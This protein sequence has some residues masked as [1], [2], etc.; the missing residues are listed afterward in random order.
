MPLRP[1]V[2]AADV[3]DPAD[4]AVWHLLMPLGLL[5]DAADTADPP[6]VLLRGVN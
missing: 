1:L 2:A 5:V 6:Q 4:T 3:A